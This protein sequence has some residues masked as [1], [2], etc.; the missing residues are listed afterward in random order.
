VQNLAKQILAPE[1]ARRVRLA[2][3]DYGD[4][5]LTGNWRAKTLD[6]NLPG[7]AALTDRDLVACLTEHNARMRSNGKPWKAIDPAEVPTL[8]SALL[9]RAPVDPCKRLK[10]IY[11]ELLGIGQLGNT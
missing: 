2:L 10:G 1:I 4:Q 7:P 5:G 6:D 9:A 8:A 11:D 3:L